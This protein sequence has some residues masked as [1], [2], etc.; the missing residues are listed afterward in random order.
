MIL[1][2]CYYKS[3]LKLRTFILFN[4]LMVLNLNKYYSIILSRCYNKL[5]FSKPCKFKGIWHDLLAHCSARF[6]HNFFSELSIRC[7]AVI[8]R[9]VKAVPKK[10]KFKTFG[11]T[12]NGKMA[13]QKVCG[14]YYLI[15]FQGQ[16]RKNGSH[17]DCLQMRIKIRQY[18]PFRI[19][20]VCVK[21]CDCYEASNLYKM[22]QS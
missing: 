15:T 8:D 12:T 10:G 3:S 4:I 6:G 7:L 18:K 21:F 20:G 22:S 19:V 2:Q 5:K 14:R 17:L 1:F 9:I 16:A 13:S 11:Y